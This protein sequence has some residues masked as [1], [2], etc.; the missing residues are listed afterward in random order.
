MPNRIIHNIDHNEIPKP[1]Y[2]YSELDE[3]LVGI[4]AINPFFANDT[5]PRAAMFN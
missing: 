2:R 1:P 5:G 3:R 4:P